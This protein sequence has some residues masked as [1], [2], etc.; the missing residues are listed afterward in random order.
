MQL[1]TELQEN[2]KRSRQ[3]NKIALPS[4]RQNRT[5][6]IAGIRDERNAFRLKTKTGRLFMLKVTRAGLALRELSETHGIHDNTSPFL[7]SLF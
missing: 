2:S 4:C 7:R 5:Y 6:R 1:L 3:P